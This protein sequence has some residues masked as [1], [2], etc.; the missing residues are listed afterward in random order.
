MKYVKYVF[1]I[2]SSDGEMAGDIVWDILSQFLAD[3]GFESF[4][5]LDNNALEAYVPSV[6][7]HDEIVRNALKS[8]PLSGIVFT[9]SAEEME[10][11]DWNEEWEKN[12]FEPIE[13]ADA[14]IRAPFH[15]PCANSA[16][17]DLVI[18]PQMAFGTGHHG[19]TSGVISLLSQLDL[20]GKSVIDMGCGT[21]ILAIYCKMKGADKVTAIDIDDWCVR[22]SLENS[23]LNGV[24]VEVIHGDASLLKNVGVAD[25]FIANINRNIILAD[26]DIYMC[27]LKNKGLLLLSGFYEE[28]VP[29]IETILNGKG[30]RIDKINSQ[31]N[32]VALQAVLDL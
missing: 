15:E 2:L 6:I 21:G 14:F 8:A 19:T 17:M 29:I 13:V 26:I 25:V 23:Q 24:D 11:K 28:D 4:E 9:F 5:K 12:F 3:G 32:W 31:N 18:H 30:W 20:R 1:E 7:Q 10:D 27:C 22:N 16:L